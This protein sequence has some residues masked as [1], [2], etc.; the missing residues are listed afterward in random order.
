MLEDPE[1]VQATLKIQGKYKKQQILKEQKQQGKLLL[2]EQ[3]S[4]KE[5]HLLSKQSQSPPP[6][7]PN[8]KQ[9]PR[10]QQEQTA[11]REYEDE[12][13][14]YQENPKTSNKAFTI[15]Q[16]DSLQRKDGA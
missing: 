6:P 9:S 5:Q 12:F 14:D 7:P 1:V 4:K 15:K 3:R 11:D 10:Q 13:S 16:Q 2:E 8:P